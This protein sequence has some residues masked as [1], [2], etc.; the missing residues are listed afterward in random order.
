MDR[1]ECRDGGSFSVYDLPIHF[2]RQ[3][4]GPYCLESDGLHT[5]WKQVSAFGEKIDAVILGEGG[6][7]ELLFIRHVWVVYGD[8]E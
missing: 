1:I 4:V 6:Y 3:S 2:D 7:D 8:C 5:E